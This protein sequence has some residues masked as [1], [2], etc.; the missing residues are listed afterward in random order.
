MIK[1]R[2][3]VDF[4]TGNRIGNSAYEYIYQVKKLNCPLTKERISDLIGA[5]VQIIKESKEQID[6]GNKYFVYTVRFTED[7]SG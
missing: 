1:N 7:S 6:E 4:I 5:N 2:L 3:S